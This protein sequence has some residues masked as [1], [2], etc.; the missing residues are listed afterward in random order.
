MSH[1]LD[2]VERIAGTVPNPKTGWIF[3]L[4]GWLALLL[5]AVYVATQWSTI[6]DP[7][8]THW[9][10]DL[11]PDDWSAKSVGSVYFPTFMGII[12]MALCGG[13]TYL[14][15]VQSV[16]GLSKATTEAE[17][18]RA[19]R[20]MAT[21]RF[22][23]LFV[24]VICGAMGVGFAFIQ[25]TGPVPALQHLTGWSFGLMMALTFASLFGG[26]G[27]YVMKNGKVDDEIRAAER[28]GIIGTRGSDQ[29]DDP[30]GNPD[31][32][33]WGMFYHNADDPAIVVEKR[34]GMGIDFNYAHWQGK[35]F[36]AVAVGILPAVLL[37]MF[38]L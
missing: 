2:V 13:L 30:Q 20:V 1:E 27:F 8:P 15:Q 7:V 31:N 14:L 3:Q 35:V 33:K 9:G 28:D 34:F 37:L 19:L 36:L 18:P 11:Q 26:L 12:V 5:G 25:I 21:M 16:A 22:T 17:V 29:V 24:S 6:P 38:V 10:P 32:W 4:L 23:L